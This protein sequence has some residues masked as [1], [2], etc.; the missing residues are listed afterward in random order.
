MQIIQIESR[1]ADIVTKGVT[2]YHLP[3]QLLHRAFS[4]NKKA[5]RVYIS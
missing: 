2:G 1:Q 4:R 5:S 3:S